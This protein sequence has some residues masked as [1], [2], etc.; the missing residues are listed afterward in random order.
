MNSA[1]STMLMQLAN[2]GILTPTTAQSATPAFATYK[3]DEKAR[4][5]FDMR[6]YN[7]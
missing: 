4:L 1:G 3:T 7:K 5:I 2:D 6:V